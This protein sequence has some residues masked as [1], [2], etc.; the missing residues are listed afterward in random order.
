MLLR[1]NSSCQTR[2]VGNC[3]WQ[4]PTGSKILEEAARQKIR[5]EAAKVVHGPAWQSFVIDSLRG[6]DYRQPYIKEMASL[7]KDMTPA[8]NVQIHTRV[9]K[10]LRAEDRD[11]QDMSRQSSDDNEGDTEGGG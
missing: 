3:C 5:T 10:L 1:Q 8:S 11:D 2:R 4:S 7:F 6:E 9:S